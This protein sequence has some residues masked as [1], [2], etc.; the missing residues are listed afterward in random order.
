MH[1]FLQEYNSI[2]GGELVT[3]KLKL[4]AWVII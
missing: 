3:I 4:L 1:L 2:T